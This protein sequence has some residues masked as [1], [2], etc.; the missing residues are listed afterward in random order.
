[1]VSF[2]GG[3]SINTPKKSKSLEIK[4]GATDFMR[5]EVCHGCCKE[6]LWG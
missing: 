6:G 4:R 5:L 1:M 2:G 3:G